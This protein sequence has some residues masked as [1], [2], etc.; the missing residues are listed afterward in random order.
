MLTMSLMDSRSVYTT[1]TRIS[2][3][4]TPTPGSVDGADVDTAADPTGPGGAVVDDASPVAPS[5]DAHAGAAS[6]SATVTAPANSRLISVF[7]PLVRG[8]DGASLIRF[9]P[10]PR[11]CAR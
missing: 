8:S 1:P 11:H 9:R 4:V 7:L 3:S 6:N 10:V 5:F 2:S